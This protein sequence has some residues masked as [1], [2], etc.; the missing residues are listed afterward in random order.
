MRAAL[1]SGGRIVILAGL[2]VFGLRRLVFI[3]AVLVPS[4]PASEAAAPSPVSLVIAARDEAAGLDPVLASVAA[5]DS[6]S[7]HV[8]LVDDGSS[9]DTPA[10]IES[11]TRARPQWSMLRLNPGVGKPAALN[12]GIA[13]AP[14]TELIA[15]CD[16]DARVAPDALAELTRAFVD[17]RVGGASAL[18][19]PANADESIV[20]RYCALELWQHQL[21]TSAAKERLRLNPPTRGAF[22]CYRREALN[23]IGGFVA[24]SL[25]E[26]VQATTALV[27]A[28]WRTRF[29]STARVVGEV[30]TSVADFGRQH[31]RW[32]RGLHD[33]APALSGTDP[34]L[35]NLIE[36]WL[37]AAGY[38]DRPL[39]LWAS[40]LATR[41]RLS[42]RVLA[43][44]LSVIAGEALVSLDRAGR[45]RDAP[46]FL[47]AAVAMFAVDAAAATAGSALQL[48]RRERTWH[49]PRRPRSGPRR[50]A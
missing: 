14:D 30:P 18:L 45:L 34:S 28:G 41:G 36:A 37:H 48:L 39:V 3:A 24:A 32:A 21:I 19:W 5:I 2:T 31:V 26:D 23:Q 9:D 13:A 11:W 35:A 7:L 29:I 33:S 15:V 46:R 17:P 25:G 44:Y 6:D 42:P 47:A 40:L 43:A 38:V 49:S 4:R 20:T 1:R 27:A 50:S 12:A 16:A 8:V 22:S 10:I